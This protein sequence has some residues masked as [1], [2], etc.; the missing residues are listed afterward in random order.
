MDQETKL[1]YDSVSPYNIIASLALDYL[2]Y[3]VERYDGYFDKS[4]EESLTKYQLEH[5]LK[6]NGVLDTDTYQALISSVKRAY[7]SDREKD[8]QLQAALD[9]LR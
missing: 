5:D 7:N 2:D 8:S 6:A 1:S 3:D 9:I 4:L